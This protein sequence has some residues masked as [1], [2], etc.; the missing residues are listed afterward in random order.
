MKPC[1]EAS[2]MSRVFFASIIEGMFRRITAGRR[3]PM[4]AFANPLAGRTRFGA[5]SPDNDPSSRNRREQ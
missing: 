5:R 1:S 2:P 3:I 4:S